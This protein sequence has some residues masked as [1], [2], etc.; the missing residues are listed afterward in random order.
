MWAL[1]NIAGDSAQYR[2]MI[3]EKE[4]MDAI[5]ELYNRL[6]VAGTG[7]GD[8]SL[9]RNIAWAVSNFCRGKPPTQYSKI[10][11]ALVIFGDIFQKEKDK[12]YLKDEECLTDAAWGL[13]YLLDST[14]SLTS[15]SQHKLTEID[16]ETGGGFDKFIE[17]GLVPA[18]VSYL[19][20]SSESITMPCVRIIGT[21][22][23][24]NDN[25]YIEVLIALSRLR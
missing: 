4:G 6:F 21:L 14:G 23:S 9:L 16:A 5:V 25:K 17:M 12:G 10:S 3:L 18:T 20:A 11:R 19:S 15:E 2:D 22:A 13:S 24:A 7:K 8:Q 1:G